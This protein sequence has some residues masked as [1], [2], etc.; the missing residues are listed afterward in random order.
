MKTLLKNF[1]IWLINF[2]RKR[3]INEY[4]NNGLDIPSLK[5]YPELNIYIFPL[6]WVKWYKSEGVRMYLKYLSLQTLKDDRV[7][8]DKIIQNN[9]K[10]INERLGE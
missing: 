4:Q 10:L 2:L 9:Q 1:S 8:K 3:F 6:N 5:N 7:R